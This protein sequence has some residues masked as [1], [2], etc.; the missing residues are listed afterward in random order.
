MIMDTSSALCLGRETVNKTKQQ[1]VV[2]NSELL[3]TQPSLK[4]TAF[5]CVFG[6]LK[7]VKVLNIL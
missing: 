3:D 4:F 2:Q 5:I 6:Y 7:Y 1:K